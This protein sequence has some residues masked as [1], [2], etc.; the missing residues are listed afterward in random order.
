[1]D[2]EALVIGAGPA[3][4]SAAA[5]LRKQG[6]DALVLE[7]S[8]DVGASWRGHYDRLRL[9]TVRWL[10]HLPG[11]RFSARHGRWVSRDGVVS[12]LEQYVRHHHLDVR[13]G[14]EVQRIEREGELWLVRTGDGDLRARYVV[15]ATG[16]NHTPY[17]PDWPGR[18]DFPGELFHASRYRNS[19]S[20][21]G[22]DVLVVGTGNTGAE[23]AVDLADGGAARV[24]LAIRTPPNV[25]LKENNGV[26]TQVVG[27]F[28]RHVP[29]RLADALAGP[30]LRKT[31]GDLTPYGMPEP[32]MGPYSRIARDDV[33]P[34]I[35][36][37][38]IDALKQGKVEP[39]AGVEGFEGAAVVL[40]DGSRVEPD[41]VIAATGYRR[42]LEPM[43]GHLGI[44]GDNG[45]PL[46]HGRNTHPSAPRLHFLGYT[47]P[48]SGMFLEIGIDARL[49]GRAIARDREASPLAREPARPPAAAAA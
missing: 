27:V 20:Y 26:P 15:V 14:V 19:E 36:V 31:V 1:M 7:R 8:E 34:I 42:G 37:G 45:R 46:A 29:P 3:G 43:V 25:V 13:T 23:I 22:R 40:A 35:D 24:R 17:V 4:L 11:L 32:P 41:A 18:E 49:I 44:L 6:V 48:V 12:Y 2:R 9:H 30:V 38:L 5:T 39:V 33:I 10:S 21:R 28:M 16:Y 47:N